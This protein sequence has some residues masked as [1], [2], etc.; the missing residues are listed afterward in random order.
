MKF[1]REMAENTASVALTGILLI[2]F[3]QNVQC[4]LP[5]SNST[6]Y[7]ILMLPYPDPLG[8]ASFRANYEDGHDISAAG[9]LAADQINNRSDILQNYTIKLILSDGGCSIRSRAVVSY[10][11]DLAHKYGTLP[12]LGLAGPGC[13]ISV[14]AILPLTTVNRTSYVSLTW[15]GKDVFVDYPNG[16]GMI[17]PDST[18]ADAYFKLAQVNNWRRIALLYTTTEAEGAIVLHRLLN[19]TKNDPNYSN[20]I[21]YESEIYDSYIPLEEIRASFI[22]IVYV[23]AT[24]ST[25]R[26]LICL[27]FHYDM[28]FPRYQWVF[29]TKVDQ[30]FDATS[31]TYNGVNYKCS[32]EDMDTALNGAL[33]FFNR[34][35]PNDNSTIIISGQTYEEY[36]KAYRSNLEPYCNMEATCETI[37]YTQWAGVTYDSI[38]ALAVAFNKSVEQYENISRYLEGMAFQKEFTK[39]I[40][41]N[42]LDVDF[43]G[44]TGHVAFDQ[45]THFI[46]P[47]L[48]L[49]QFNEGRQSDVVMIYVHSDN[50]LIEIQGKNAHFVNS[51]F[52]AIHR[53][54]PLSATLSVIA[55]SFLILLVTVAIQVIN[56]VYRDYSS[57]KA[58]SH[59]LNHI[60][61]VGFYLILMGIVV[62]TLQR[63]TVTMD[64]NIE[65]LCCHIVPWSVSIGFALILG[66]QCLK[67]W[68]LYYIFKRK[69]LVNQTRNKLVLLKDKTLAGIMCVIV[70]ID[71]LVLTIWSTIAPPV[72][73]KRI[74]QNLDGSE[75]IEQQCASNKL[76]EFSVVLGGEKMLFL[77]I[78]LVF[79]L[80]T[81]HIHLKEFETKNVVI[82]V[83]LL[84]VMSILGIPLYLIITIPSLG[85]NLTIQV[86]V[87]NGLLLSVL[88][89]CLVVLY[90]PPLVP[91]VREKCFAPG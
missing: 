55:C 53:H 23:V 54:L 10:A 68:R 26:K 40:Q 15:G 27:A 80:L 3:L 18:F 70:A 43:Q 24:T 57:I 69:I 21:S 16:F 44:A 78:S 5:G 75:I 85:L 76:V 2:L 50:K 12:V 61:L 65:S 71:I 58:T 13:D 47:Q 74:I 67:T 77:L 42:M 38:W 35:S 91:L 86:L 37:V 31:F 52:E 59:R 83:Y 14:G 4:M 64:R 33:S 32:N 89:V 20:L 19:V 9:F 90:L 39:I 60:I 11:K 73:E 30:D 82:L 29:E 56:V 36:D 62:Y 28:L 45:K 34:F 17:G 63:A 6:I 48:N 8:R 22:R 41:L 7:V 66:T 1:S 88:C 72:P 81:R 84:S 79:A 25:S 87:L 49:I 51:S 46:R